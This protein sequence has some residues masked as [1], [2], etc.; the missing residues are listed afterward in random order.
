[1]IIC[2]SCE[3]DYRKHTTYNYNDYQ[4]H[5]ITHKLD[6]VPQEKY[7]LYIYQNKGCNKLNQ[8]SIF[9]V[10]LIPCVRLEQPF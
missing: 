4:Y 10:E 7:A 3:P 9:S 6:Y 5:Q 1:M 8:N 2:W